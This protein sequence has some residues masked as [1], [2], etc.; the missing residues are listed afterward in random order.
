[1]LPVRTTGN[2]SHLVGAFGL[3]AR[4]TL[5]GVAGVAGAAAATYTTAGVAGSPEAP[6]DAA[7]GVA[8]QP[9]SSFTC[10]NREP[11]L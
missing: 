8:W 5:D 10:R 6:G 4:N 3:G 9:C 11:L 7:R 1:M 2:R